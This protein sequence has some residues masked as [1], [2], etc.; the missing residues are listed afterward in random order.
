[1][2]ERKNQT[3]SDELIRRFLLGNLG[4]TKQ[5]RFERSLFMND[6]LEERVRL[7][8]LELCDD[9]VAGRLV[10]TERTLFQERFLLTAE[11]KE[12]LA[13]SAALHD[14][15]RVSPSPALA[16]WRKPATNLFDF[17]RYGWR[18][19]FAALVLLLLVA[20]AV[21]ITKDHS[22]IALPP[23]IPKS[24]LPKPTVTATPQVAHH[25]NNPS[26]PVHSEAAPVLPSHEEPTTRI[27]LASNTPFG[28]APSVDI[29]TAGFS[30][31]LILD[32]PLV[33]SYDVNVTTTSGESVFSAKGVKRTAKGSLL[34]DLP[35]G[36][37]RPGDFQINLTG[38]EG[39]SRRSAGM[40]YFRVR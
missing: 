5:A 4:R 37:I 18:Y 22:H 26:A 20:G 30:F 27:R 12:N 25:P 28:A 29:H 24:A 6:A 34:V 16:S 19:A 17:R 23:F 8:E 40:F 9:Y 14:K 21:L 36:T 10:R 33:D 1:M 15:F 39:E 13:T 31:E 2:K 3:Y 7:A 35:P 32:Q 11:R 38:I